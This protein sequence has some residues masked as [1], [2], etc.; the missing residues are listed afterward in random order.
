MGTLLSKSQVYFLNNCVLLITFTLNLNKIL[1]SNE[2]KIQLKLFKQVFFVEISLYQFP[3]KRSCIIVSKDLPYDVIHT[4]D[5]LGLLHFVVDQGCLGED[6]HITA[7]L[8]QKPIFIRLALSL[9]KHCNK[10]NP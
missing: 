4:H 9:R 6:P 10:E 5:A 3:S 1:L 7:S 8:R 2:I